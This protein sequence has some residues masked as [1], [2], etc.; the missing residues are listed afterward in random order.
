MWPWLVG[1]P[2][3]RRYLLTGDPLD[4]RE[5]ARIGLVTASAPTMTELDEMVDE[6]ILKLTRLSPYAVGSTKAAIN[7]HLRRIAEGAIEAHLG[8]W[9]TRAYLSAD[10]REALAATLEDRP[11]RFTGA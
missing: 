9:E 1:F 6:M 11:P 8:Q 2:L 7:L 4:G 10:H 3:A 5:A